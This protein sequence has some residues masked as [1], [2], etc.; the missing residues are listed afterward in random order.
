MWGSSP[1]KFLE[2]RRQI[3]HSGR[4]PVQNYTSKL[5]LH[6]VLDVPCPL[7][8]FLFFFGTAMAV[9]AVP[10]APALACKVMVKVAMRET[11]AR[12]IEAYVLG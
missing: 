2:F 10:V 7:F 9:P 6:M 12:C 8:C 11:V 4:L 1:R 3:L 5:F